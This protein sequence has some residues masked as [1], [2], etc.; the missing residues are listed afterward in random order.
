MSRQYLPAAVFRKEF[1]AFKLSE[2]PFEPVDYPGTKP[3]PVGDNA[4]FILDGRC[5]FQ[6]LGIEDILYTADVYTY[7]YNSIVHRHSLHTH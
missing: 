5:T 3:V 2:N 1:P 4:S 7:A 6:K